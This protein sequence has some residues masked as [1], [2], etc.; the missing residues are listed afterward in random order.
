MLKWSALSQCR[1]G[2]EVQETEIDSSV[3]RSQ[4]QKHPG[5]RVKRPDETDHAHIPCTREQKHIWR[6]VQLR[7]RVQG[8]MI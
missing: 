7:A 4:D 8:E 1:V 2:E 5:G 6:A 3:V